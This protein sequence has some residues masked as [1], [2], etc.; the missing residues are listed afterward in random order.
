MIKRKIDKFYLFSLISGFIIMFFILFP[1]INT[2]A[3]TNTSLIVD[4]LHEKA[5]IN[6]IIRSVKT[7]SIATFFSAILAIPFAYFLVRSNIKFKKLIESIIDVP[8]VLP[9]TVAG[10]ILLSVLSKKSMIG[11]FFYRNNIEILGSEIAII[12]AM[13]FVSLPIMFNSCK[14]AFKWIP[15]RTENVSR[16]LGASNFETFIYITFPLAWKDILGG[17]IL[18]FARSISEFGAVI[19]LAY[20]PMIAP[21]LIYERFTN[22]GISYAMPIAIILLVVSLS[23]F[24]LLRVLSLSGKR[25][26]N[27]RN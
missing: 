13:I 14:E 27:D 26:H 21:T 22:Y 10:I 25:Y 9:H 1:L 24:L 2:F 6:V 11:S 16:I 20:H 15:E 18:T 7:A 5:V 8:I 12:I 4:T 23:I 3:W 19:I 17:M